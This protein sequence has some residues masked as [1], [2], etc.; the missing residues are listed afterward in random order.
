MPKFRVV[1]HML[2]VKYLK[3]CVFHNTEFDQGRIWEVFTVLIQVAPY[4]P[5]LFSDLSNLCLRENAK[6]KGRG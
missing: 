3:S 2:D 4:L 5:P 6:H 1:C